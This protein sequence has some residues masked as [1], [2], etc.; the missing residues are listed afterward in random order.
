MSQFLLFWMCKFYSWRALRL[1][2]IINYLRLKCNQQFQCLNH[3]I[4][5]YLTRG[6]SINTSLLIGFGIFLLFQSTCVSLTV[7]VWAKSTI[8]KSDY[9]TIAIDLLISCLLL[10]WSL[11]F[12]LFLN[13]FISLLCYLSN[14]ILFVWCLSITLCSECCIK[15]IS[16][17]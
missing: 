12:H 17:N 6:N 5:P 11:C 15:V 10:S 2:E 7:M 9:W 16:L 8:L 13:V 4:K 3:S 14:F 1:S